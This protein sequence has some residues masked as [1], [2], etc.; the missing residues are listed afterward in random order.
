MMVQRLA[1]LV[2]LLVKSQSLSAAGP[3]FLPATSPLVRWSGR[4]VRV[5]NTVQFDWIGT[6]AR[7]SVVNASW[8][9]IVAT[10]TAPKMGTRLRA[11][12]SDQGFELYPLVSFWISPLA[13]SNE[14]LLFAIESPVLANRTVTIENMIGA[15]SATGITTVHGRLSVDEL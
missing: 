9:T 4:T 2:L 6:S 12:V 11:Y 5:S 8:V 1:V 13:P 7:V 15:S 3:R 10:T 14:T